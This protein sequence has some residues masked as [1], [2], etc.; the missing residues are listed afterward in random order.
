LGAEPAV[1][2]DGLAGRREIN[3][4]RVSFSSYGA[5]MGVISLSYLFGDAYIGEP[6]SQLENAL[7]TAFQAEQEGASDTLIIVNITL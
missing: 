2:V 4:A 3:V 5:A 1:A 6:V 7:Q